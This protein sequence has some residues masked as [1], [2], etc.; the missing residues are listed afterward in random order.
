MKLN[1]IRTP[2][3]GT[4]SPAA[5]GR[6]RKPETQS[7]ILRAA[8]DILVEEGF[9]ALKME[10]VSMRA[11]VGKTT[12]YRRWKSVPELVIDLLEHANEAWPMP[13]TD[14][15][16]ITEA[17]SQLYRN[18]ICGMS[19]PGKIIPVLI[20]EG[21]QNPSLAELLHDRFVLPRRRLAIAII[22]KAKVR[23]D[24]SSDVDNEAAID[25]FMGRMWYRHLVTGGRITIDD[26][27][28]VI[29]LLVRGLRGK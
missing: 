20:A 19:G 24:V 22:E 3:N 26:E 28:K 7:H 23:G 12:V 29:E 16:S 8:A 4:P 6:P 1:M 13:Q 2:P 15:E 10:R 11:G 18:W 21:I 17:L 14:S 27:G 25:M 9:R 5:I